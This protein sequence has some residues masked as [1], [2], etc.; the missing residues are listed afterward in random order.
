MGSSV[1]VIIPCYNLGRYLD[2]AVASVL[3]QTFQ[4]FEILIVDDGSTDAATR[5]VLDGYSRPR[6]R[7][8]RTA[9]AGLA[10]ARNHGIERAQGRYVCALDADDTLEPAFLEKLVRVLDADASLTFSSCWLRTFGDE[11]WEWTPERCDLPA[12]LWE[13]TVLTA[14]LVRRDAVVAIG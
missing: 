3:A 6:T 9:H 10:A 8:F 7:V 11:S 13:N 1:S 12:L 2:E 14:A 5:A 4:D